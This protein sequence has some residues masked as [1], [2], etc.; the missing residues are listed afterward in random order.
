MRRGFGALVTLTLLLLFQTA[1]FSAD[2]PAP[3]IED[4]ISRLGSERWN[5]RTEARKRLVEHGLAAL[6]ALR[7]ACENRNP[8]VAS[9]A[10]RAISEIWDRFSKQ[11]LRQRL[12]T[13]PGD[14]GRLERLIGQIPN[15]LDMLIDPNQLS[16]HHLM[17]K[18]EETCSPD[19]SPVLV[20]LLGSESKQLRRR[21]AIQLAQIGGMDTIERLEPLIASTNPEIACAAMHAASMMRGRTTE[22]RLLKLLDHN[23]PIIAREAA[24]ALLMYYGNP[25]GYAALRGYRLDPDI[26]EGTKIRYAFIRLASLLPANIVLDPPLERAAATT[27]YREEPGGE[28]RFRELLK[29]F[30]APLPGVTAKP[31]YGTVFIASPERHAELPDFVPAELVSGGECT[32]AHRLRNC[33]VDAN[34]EDTR[35]ETALTHVTANLEVS[36]QMHPD[37]DFGNAVTF[38]HFSGLTAENALRCLLFPRGFGYY[39]EEKKLHILTL[40]ELA[41]KLSERR[42]TVLESGDI[43]ALLSYLNHTDSRLSLRARQALMG[44]GNEAIAAA[45]ERFGPDILEQ[46]TAARGFLISA[47][48]STLPGSSLIDS[49]LNKTIAF[50]ADDLPLATILSRLSGYTGVEFVLGFSPGTRKELEKVRVTCKADIITVGEVL[51]QITGESGIIFR[52][53]PRDIFFST[54]SDLG[55]YAVAGSLLSIVEKEPASAVQLLQR[56]T[57]RLHDAGEEGIGEWLKWWESV[58]GF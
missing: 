15:V 41:R 24:G 25:T 29:S 19:A 55:D 26:G 44:L 21:A 57:G 56:L 16:R 17:D 40:K 52:I 53:R 20:E 33:V 47:Y 5:E 13:F 31:R 4:L 49:T 2:K 38:A 14:N 46:G 45:V 34:F 11:G 8:E 37:V 27:G 51:E 48:L 7:N 1:V 18:L 30:A 3:T 32:A 22:L 6:P 9:Q 43:P 23:S 35:L 12:T 54:E 42:E 58:R 36:L 39:L 50:V 28:G 10:R